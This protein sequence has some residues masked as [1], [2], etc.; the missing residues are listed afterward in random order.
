MKIWFDDEIKDYFDWLDFKYFTLYW[1]L[2]HL[3][4][5]KEAKGE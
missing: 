3:H 4:F 2:K 5:K 1:F